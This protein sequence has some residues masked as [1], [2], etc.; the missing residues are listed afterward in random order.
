MVG[1]SEFPRGKGETACLKEVP[2]SIWVADEPSFH[3]SHSQLSF[4]VEMDKA[5]Q[6]L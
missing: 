5:Y 4:S 6:K 2:T 1:D 3:F